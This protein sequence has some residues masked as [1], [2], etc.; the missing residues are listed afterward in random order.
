MLLVWKGIQLDI[1]LSGWMVA[2]AV[3]AT[4]TG[5]TLLEVFFL[6]PYL[7]R[8]IMH[9]D[10]QLKWYSIWEGPRL[11]KRP[12]PPPPPRGVNGVNIKDYY[13]GH[14]TLDELQCLRASES[15][16]NSVQSSATSSDLE[17]SDHMP[18]RRPSSASSQGIPPRPE[19]K[20]YRFPVLFWR[21]NRIVLHGLEQDVI[22]M[23][24]RSMLLNWNIEDM[25]ARAPRYDNRAEYMYSSLQILTAATASFIHGANDVSNAIAPFASAYWIWQTGKIEKTAPVPF[26]VLYVPACHSIHFELLTDILEPQVLRRCWHR[27][28]PAN[29]RVPRHAKSGKSSHAHDALARILYGTRQRHDSPRCDP[30]RA[31]RFHSKS[32]FCRS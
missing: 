7:W 26:W 10:W 27:H 25:H 14:L 5:V 16:L 8:R 2:V 17:K 32:L 19:G 21:F 23:Q 18:S 13:K 15:L 29:L 31:S 24:K 28:R 11:L 6:L 30:T 4:A 12:P 9:E 22:K 1:E 20:W 3:V